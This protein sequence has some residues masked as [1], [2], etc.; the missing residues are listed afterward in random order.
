LPLSRYIARQPIFDRDQK[1]YAYELLF[2]SG[3]KNLF[4]QID[5]DQAT[6]R[7]ISDSVLLFGGHD[8]TG[9]KR[10]FINFTRNLLLKGYG[11]L[12][13]QQWLVVEVLENVEPDAEVVEA[14]RKL[15][16]EGYQIALDDFV[17]T[18]DYWDLIDLADIIKVDFMVSPPE[19]RRQYAREFIPRGLALLAEK[20]ETQAEFEEAAG[21]GYQ[22]FQGYFFARPTVLTGQDLPTFKANGLAL[23]QEINREDM[24]FEA[25]EEVIKR[26]AGLSYKLMRYAN[27]VHFAS[28]T[29][30][31]SIKHALGK[32]GEN[33]ARR[34]ISLVVLSD[35]GRDRPD[36]L[37]VTTL[38]R[39]KF[40]DLI[41]PS[42][43]LGGRASEMF[44]TGLFSLMDAFLNQP[45]EEAIEDLP[46]DTDVKQ[47]LLGKKNRFGYSLALAEALERARWKEVQ[48][49]C[50]RLKLEDRH[51]TQRYLEAIEWA[52]EVFGQALS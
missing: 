35:L 27:S 17:F 45:M 34:F 46:I 8:L 22:Y 38:T 28:R 11:A 23:L 41:A 50:E 13:P 40:L 33:E 21:L 25:L 16:D 24:D 36:E 31:N 26:E 43:G 44:L 14:C 42:I 52:D 7:V 29:Q 2:R 12:L 4:D 10:A 49:R 47:G 39:A 19:E 51:V 1:V 15:K 18:E 48:A 9:G 6:S 5:G 20:V 30:V 32:L 3:L 37:M